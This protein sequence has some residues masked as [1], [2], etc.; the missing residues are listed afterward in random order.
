MV[1][2][3]RSKQGGSR[4]DHPNF[5]PSSPLEHTQ[6]FFPPAIYLGSFEP[7]HRDFDIHP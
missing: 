4:L 6:R 1:M 3:E 5:N 7:Y 2:K